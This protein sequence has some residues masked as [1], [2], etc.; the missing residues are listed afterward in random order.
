MLTLLTLGKLKGNFSYL[1]TGEAE[2]RKR[3]QGFTQLELIELPDE[4][5]TATC[6]PHVALVR[7]AE[8]LQ[9][10][11]SAANLTIALSERG[12]QWTSQ[13]L[14]AQ[15]N[16]WLERAGEA[17]PPSNPSSPPPGRKTG[18]KGSRKPPRGGIL[19]IVGSAHGLSEDILQQADVTWSLS[20][21]TYPHPLVRLLVLE[22]LYRAFTIR[23][24]LPYHK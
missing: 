13:Q 9:P 5:I 1:A 15:L 8:R 4:T 2:Y 14:S 18:A 6:P 22:Q 19:F 7:E 11:R 10:Y 3:L 12:T 20:P 16:R 17:S 23:Q 24:G 21:L